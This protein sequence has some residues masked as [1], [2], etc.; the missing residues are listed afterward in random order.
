MIIYFKPTVSLKHVLTQNNIHDQNLL[1]NFN[2]NL[3]N[4]VLE[5]LVSRL[6]S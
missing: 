3:T 6:Y 4:V 5:M 1:V 2:E